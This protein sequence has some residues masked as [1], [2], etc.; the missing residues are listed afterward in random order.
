[1]TSPSLPT[2]SVLIVDDSQ[3]S[4]EALR[5]VLR[6]DGFRVSA[7]V[8][9]RVRALAEVKQNPPD[10]ICVDIAAGGDAALALVAELRESAAEACLVVISGNADRLAVQKAI[11]SGAMGYVIKPFTAL[12]V[13]ATLR[14]VREIAQRKRTNHAL[15]A[16][17]GQRRVV[18]I[19]Q[20]EEICRQLRW[21][22]EDGG[23]S[24]V[25]ETRDGL[26]GLI[27]VDREAPDLVCLDADLPLV[28]GLNALNAIKACHP[29]IRCMLVSEHADRGSV[30]AC[31]A[32]GATG[33]LI[34]PF[35]PVHV[36]HEV[37]QA[38]GGRRDGP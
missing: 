11:N 8:S 36:L 28:D 10:I 3:V 31:I 17:T 2:T 38:L 13:Q 37:A 18:L 5:T 9:G 20:D 25:A 24:I 1:M 35:N 21:V 29:T 4:A 15:P 32:G 6:Q 27:A 12:Q 19:E 34:K 30:T 7:M 22:L 14:R 23:Y 33:Y 26:E 16:S